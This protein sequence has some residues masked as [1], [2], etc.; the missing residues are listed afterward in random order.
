MKNLIIIFLSVFILSCATPPQISDDAFISSRP[1][2][3]VQFHEPFIE[4]PVKSYRYQEGEAKIYEFEVDNRQSIFI[5][6]DSHIPS[7]TGYFFYGPEKILASRGRMILDSVVIDD[8]QWTK[9]VYVFN[10]RY[11]VTGYFIL[12]NE[13][14]ISV[15]RIYDCKHKCEDEIKSFRKGMVLNPEQ[16]KLWDEAFVS[17]D[18]LFSIGRN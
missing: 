8:R 16:G 5:E 1:N 14:A 18:Q 4:K 2:F 3:K 9:F 7:R 13:T 15:G 11:L 12:T 6:I 17:T 10:K